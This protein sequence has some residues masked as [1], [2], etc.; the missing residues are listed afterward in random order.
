MENIQLL[1]TMAQQ[2]ESLSDLTLQ[3]QSSLHLSIAFIITA[4]FEQAPARGELPLS[5]QENLT[6]FFFHLLLQ[7]YQT[8]RS[9]AFYAEQLCITPKYLTTTVKRITGYSIQD[10]INDI[11][12]ITAKRYLRTSYR[13]IQDISEELHFQ[14]A[15]SF[16]RFF[17]QHTGCTPL[18]YRKDND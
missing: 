15:S 3:L 13:T 14:T 1:H 6:K 11:T 8:Q 16:I 17:R 5:R 10:W 4:S 9:V 7:H 18:K 2:Y 12:I